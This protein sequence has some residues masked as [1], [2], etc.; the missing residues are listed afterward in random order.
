MSLG[1]THGRLC[2]IK[3][4]RNETI[5]VPKGGPSPGIT[6]TRNVVVRADALL[7]QPVADLPGED[8]GTLALVRRDLGDDFGG[9]DA[10]LGAADGAW[11][12][13]ARLVV[14]APVHDQNIALKLAPDT[15]LPRILD[16]HPLDTCRMREI[17]QGRAPEWA[18]STIFCLVESGRGRPL[19]N[20]PP[21][22]FTPLCPAHSHAT[23]RIFR[24]AYY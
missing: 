14:P 4:P 13:G 18:S 15:Y 21:S 17:S 9:G 5:T 6:Y 3:S 22:W 2:V 7:Q 16:T 24:N 1:V 8:R 11:S 19:T 10:R 23:V 12:D 20:T